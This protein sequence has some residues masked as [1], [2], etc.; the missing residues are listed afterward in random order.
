LVHG[1]E[2]NVRSKGGFAPLLFAAQRGAT[3][4]AHLLLD[5]GAEIN[6]TAAKDGLTPLSLA[7]ASGHK[8]LPALLIE[9]GADTN[10]ADSRG[11]TAL[12]YAAAE[13][14]K[15]E[16]VHA[17]I[18]SGAKLD[19]RITK[20]PPRANE[21][22]Y[23]LPGATPIFMAARV[24]NLPAVRALL[25]AGADP[26]MATNQ[27]TTPFAVAAGVGYPQDR[28]WYE[29]EKKDFLEIVKL[30]ADRGADINAA[31][32]NGWT[33]LHGAAYKGL[34]E[35]MKFLIA[36]GADIEAV[37]L[38]GQTPLVIAGG[39]QTVEIGDH[40]YQS[41]RIERKHSFDLLISLGA[42][43]LGK[44][45]VHLVETATTAE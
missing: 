28:D 34:D 18:K 9:R 19:A 24:A 37:D 43:P 3:A 22:G 8:E 6:A 10:I 42:K 16:L 27:Q 31:G 1:A 2:P 33:P 21:G 20:D 32:E 12:H 17:L 36:R 44:S 29:S 39:L 41:P 11:Y 25:D 14:G 45:G 40:F 35:I 13:V 5:A 4:S 26:L 23:S 15:V 7:I 30:L 38:F